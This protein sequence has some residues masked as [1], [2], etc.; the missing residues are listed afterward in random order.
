MTGGMK[1]KC[2]LG[3]SSQVGLMLWFP[4]CH[5]PHATLHQPL[6]FIH[7]LHTSA[8][9]F[10]FGCSHESPALHGGLSRRLAPVRVGPHV[11]AGLRKTLEADPGRVDGALTLVE[12]EV[13]QEGTESAAD[14]GSDHGDLNDDKR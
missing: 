2:L 7:C 3:Q 4:C 13:V 6:Y 8:G 10:F 9:D 12:E 5:G 14:E 1:G 11:A